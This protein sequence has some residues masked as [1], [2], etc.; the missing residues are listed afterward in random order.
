MEHIPQPSL[1]R[2]QATFFQPYRRRLLITC[3]SVPVAEQQI[4]T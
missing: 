2:V 4:D 1:D 3:A